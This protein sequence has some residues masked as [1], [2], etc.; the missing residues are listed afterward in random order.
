MFEKI[1][2]RRSDNGPSLTAGELAEALLF[3]Q[4]VHLVLDYGC[5]NG[6]IKQIGMPTLVS[7]LTRPNVSAVYCENMLGT[8]TETKNNVATHSFVAFSFAGDKEVGALN[9]R[10]KILEYQLTKI[11][12]YDKK[13]A[14]RL[15]ERFRRKVPFR[16]LTKDH[17]IEGGIL[18]AAKLD[19]HDHSF[20]HDA[21]RLTLFELIG[22]EN[23][24][25]NFTFKAHSSKSGFQIE[26][27]IDFL[28]INEE[29]KK[30]QS[31]DG[32]ITPAHLIGNVLNARA[33]TILASYY[34]GEFYTS[35]LTSDIIQIK[36]FELLRRIGIEKKE[37]QEFTKIVVSTAPSLREVINSKERSFDEFLTMLD[38][39]QRFREWAK[40]VN[41]DEKLV[42]EYWNEVSSEGWINKLPSKALRY[43]IGATV[44]AVEPVYGLVVSA[45][46]S[47]LLEK[48]IGGWRP[49]HFVER[50]LKPFI[51]DER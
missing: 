43:L 21:V 39:S 15:V 42:K 27:D 34:G 40:G 26:T 13:Q 51:E 32:D 17:F 49:S 45:A 19:L 48:I 38:K 4:S 18:K 41:P 14:K 33:D 29:I 1:V 16:D 23:T 9:S 35:N 37:L 28:R 20:I 47:F 7:L 31:F 10:K 25:Q 44:G 46:D 30:R 11:H 36:Y 5:L 8:H 12:A 50:T 6:L 2:L 24:P 3:Y 22:Q